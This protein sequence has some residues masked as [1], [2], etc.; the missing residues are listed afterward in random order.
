MSQRCPCTGSQAP[1]QSLGRLVQSDGRVGRVVCSMLG[2]PAPLRTS[3]VFSPGPQ[4]C[5]L[6]VEYGRDD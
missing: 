1:R 6:S 3:T 5:L 2:V 4:L